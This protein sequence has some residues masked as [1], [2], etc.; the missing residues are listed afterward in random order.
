MKTLDITLDL[1]TCALCPTAA[2]MSIG[3]VAW[4]RTNDDTP[5]FEDDFCA[6]I[7]MRSMLVNGF[8]VD[9]KTLEWWDTQS[10]EAKKA[11]LADDTDYDADVPCR[12]I[13]TAVK[14]L[15]AWIEQTRKAHEADAVNLW[16]QGSD[17]DIAILRNICYKYGIEIPV[18]YTNFRDHRTFFLESARAICDANGTEF[19]QKDAYKLVE[20]YAD[21]KGVP[22]DPVFDCKRSIYSAWQ[23]MKHMRCLIQNNSSLVS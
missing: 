13:V 15:F 10:E 22:H 6:H 16:S 3:A 2:V 20:D 18:P 8:T 5:F 1:E 7:D 14:D 23:M 11:V 9:P 4:D 12:D 21:E 17:F 19:R